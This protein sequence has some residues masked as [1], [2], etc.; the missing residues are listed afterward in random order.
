MLYGPYINVG[1][2]RLCYW[3]TRFEFIDNGWWAKWLKY[4]FLRFL[5]WIPWRTNALY[6]GWL[7]WNFF[8]SYAQ[9][10]SSSMNY[11]VMKLPNKI[12][13]SSVINSSFLLVFLFRSQF[14]NRV[15]TILRK[16]E[17][18]ST[19]IILGPSD[20]VSYWSMLSP[21]SCVQLTTLTRFRWTIWDNRTF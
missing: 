8:S 12:F 19:R 9:V 3:V 15:P 6:C 20:T 2:N 14:E 4:D 1:S 13:C 21:Q 16:G 10:A 7:H 18:D 11:N 5:T 17:T